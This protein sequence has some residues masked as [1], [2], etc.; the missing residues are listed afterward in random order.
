MYY[1]VTICVPEMRTGTRQKSLPIT[2]TVKEEVNGEVRERSVT[3]YK[4]VMEEFSYTV[5]VPRRETKVGELDLQKVNAFETNGKTIPIDKLRKRLTGDKLVVFSANDQM[6]PDYYAWVFKPG[7]IILA[8]KQGKPAERPLPSNEVPPQ[9]PAPV[10]PIPA[11]APPPVPAP[12]PGN[13]L[14]IPTPQ[15]PEPP[16]A[17][18]D[19]LGGPPTLSDKSSDHLGKGLSIDQS[20]PTLP[21]PLFIIASRDQN[22]HIKLRQL[23][24]TSLDIVGQKV[25]N[26]EGKKKNISIKMAKTVRHYEFTF[27]SEKEVEFY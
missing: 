27:I 6:I 15:Q 13:D 4:T 20:L 11:P 14:P 16:T 3:D 26:Q 2:K 1:E 7:T 25:V 5:S 17:P 12:A 9:P 24:E 10:E 8:F 19:G 23:K 18:N 22:E 21:A